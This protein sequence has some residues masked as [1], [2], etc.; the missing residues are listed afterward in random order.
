M[1]LIN[2][3]PVGNNNFLLWDFSVPKRRCANIPSAQN[4][5]VQSGGI[6]VSFGQ[7]FININLHTLKTLC[8]FHHF[9]AASCSGGILLNY[10]E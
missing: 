1:V 7:Q 3:L 10:F 4:C 5:F 9:S 6:L 2:S 8:T